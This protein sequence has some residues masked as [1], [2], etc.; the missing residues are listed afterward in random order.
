MAKKT[1][2]ALG[3]GA[4]LGPAH[5]G[6][7]K[8]L[9]EKEISVDCI[10][11]TSIGAFIAALYAGGVSVEKMDEMAH[12]IDWLDITELTLSRMGLLSNN[13]LA[14]IVGDL[15]GEKNIEDLDIPLAIVTTDITAGKKY[16]FKEGP[17]SL[18]VTAS[19]CVPGIFSPVE[20]KDKLFVDGGVLEN[21]PISPLKSMDAD[22]IIG[23]DLNK[24]EDYK[25][26]ENIFEVIYNSLNILLVN[27]TQVQTN[28][29]DFLICP[30][31]SGF[32]LT[33]IERVDE[34]IRRGYDS[35]L[36]SIED[37]KK[38]AE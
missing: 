10:S 30:D 8:A 5:I 13:K 12:S 4:A 7:L 27:A 16:I 21:V 2:L 17:V 15:I 11:G 6:V 33:R 9:K 24:H 32:S 23:V 25:A 20:Y 3:G 36:K 14:D 37:I 19:S 29:A 18:A 26:P 28:E 38:A 31:L 34:M 35:A 22:M 1:G